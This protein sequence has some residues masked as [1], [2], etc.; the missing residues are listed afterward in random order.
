MPDRAEEGQR[1]PA[2]IA[3]GEAVGAIAAGNANPA[4]HC[5]LALQNGHRAKQVANRELQVEHTEA[6]DV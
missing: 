3:R 1:K 4:G 5:L 6:G 2:S